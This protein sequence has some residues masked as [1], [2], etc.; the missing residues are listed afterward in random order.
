M[1]GP[2]VEEE[3]TAEEKQIYEMLPAEVGTDVQWFV[4]NHVW[5]AVNVRLQKIP[6][7]QEDVDR[8]TMHLSAIQQTQTLSRQ[9][10]HHM[11]QQA[12]VVGDAVVTAIKED[13]GRWLS[14]ARARALEAP[15]QFA[16][17]LWEEFV[18]AVRCAGVAI[19]F[20]YRES[21]GREAH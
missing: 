17:D 1:G 10:L 11:K 13:K 16:G 21:P 9:T 5:R 18:V 2:R 20:T 3:E 12:E 8:A 15:A 4:W 19:Y 6:Q 7:A 14:V